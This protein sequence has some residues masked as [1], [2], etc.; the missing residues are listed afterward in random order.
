MTFRCNVK[1]SYPYSP[2]IYNTKVSFLYRKNTP[3]NLSMWVSSIPY[4]WYL[5]AQ[6]GKKKPSPSTIS[7]APNISQLKSRQITALYAIIRKIPLCP[8]LLK[9]KKKRVQKAAILSSAKLK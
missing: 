6:R 7:A 9:A 3:P 4:A 1:T 8:P 5:T 2:L